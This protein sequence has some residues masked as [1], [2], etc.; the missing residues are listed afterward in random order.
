MGMLCAVSSRGSN[1][2]RRRF[3]HTMSSLQGA[4]V[5]AD[6]GV[7]GKLAEDSS[8]TPLPVARGACFLFKTQIVLSL[9]LTFR[10]RFLFLSICLIGLPVALHGQLNPVSGI[11]S[12]PL[13]G[14][15]HDYLQG[16]ND[17]VDPSSGSLSIRIAAP[18]PKERGMNLPHY[19][20]A[21]DTNGQYN[22][23]PYYTTESTGYQILTA[24]YLFQDPVTNT[25][26]PGTV[27]FQY[28]TTP[29]GTGAGQVDCDYQTN[30]VFT[31]PSGGRHNLDLQWQY[32]PF[33]DR[34]ASDACA[35]LG[36]YNHFEGGDESYKATIVPNATNNR[37]N[38]LY[39][40]DSHGNTFSIPHASGGYANANG[41]IT[42]IPEDTNGNGSDGT[43]R[44]YTVQVGPTGGAS[45]GF[46]RV[47][48]HSWPCRTL[49][50]KL[51][52]VSLQCDVRILR[53]MYTHRFDIFQL[54]RFHLDD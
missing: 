29:Y 28:W 18:A 43:G 42:T 10:Q 51:P 40:A 22:F 11:T 5:G 41:V 32:G 2:I 39:I 15:G 24:I 53:F 3:R 35:A 36:I 48:C 8:L 6:A 49:P 14:S 16:L 13:A 45:A 12:T 33:A 31:D 27:S 47:R 4:T 20:L 54:V 50:D 46:A 23:T 19:V 44:N 34:Q 25:S 26:T 17:I 21:Y 37:D 38:A 7:I 30:Y 9:L 1:G 52:V